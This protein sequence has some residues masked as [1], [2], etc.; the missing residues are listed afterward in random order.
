MNEHEGGFEFFAVTADTG[1]RAWGPDLPA[2]F[3]QAARA[4]WS[5]LVEST[6]VEPRKTVGVSV[7]A[8]ERDALLVAW[9]N[10]LLYLYETQGLIGADCAIR[11]MTDMGLSAARRAAGRPESWWMC[12][13]A[14]SIGQLGNWSTWQL[15][16][17]LS[18]NRGWVFSN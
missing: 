16:E 7:G 8:G 9:L 18:R 2:V 15:V 12:E 5:L 11:S 1:I 17:Q 6:S 13:A 10:E 14:E 3:R 4:L